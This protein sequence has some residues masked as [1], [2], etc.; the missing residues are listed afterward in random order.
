M[1]LLWSNSRN[2]RQR[3]PVDVLMTVRS[4]SRAA[5]YQR[6][7]GSSYFGRQAP[8]CR[9]RDPSFRR[10]AVLNPAFVASPYSGAARRFV[11]RPWPFREVLELDSNPVGIHPLDVGFSARQPELTNAS[12]PTRVVLHRRPPKPAVSSNRIKGE[13]AYNI[14]TR[15]PC[16]LPVS[17]SRSATY[18]RC[19]LAA[20]S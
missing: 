9:V 13:R 12:Q 10:L 1:R 18:S 19:H 6:N 2:N 5:M 17:G 20:S 7:S 4:N 8:A 11:G 14:C 16:Q 15:E 3:L